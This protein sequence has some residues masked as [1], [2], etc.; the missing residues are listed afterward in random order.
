MLAYLGLQYGSVDEAGVSPTEREFNLA[1]E[2][3]KYRL[4]YLKSVS[5]ER[6]NPRMTALIAKAEKEG[7]PQVLQEYR[8]PQTRIVGIVVRVLAQPVFTFRAP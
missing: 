4:I 1:S 5:N 3:H 2:R 6:R 7:G 8:R